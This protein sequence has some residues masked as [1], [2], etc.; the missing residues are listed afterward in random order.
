MRSL[1]ADYA[2]LPGLLPEN[3]LLLTNP[4]N[5]RLV[6]KLTLK[7]L[8][9]ACP[10]STRNRLYM[11]RE[12]SLRWILKDFEVRD[13]TIIWEWHRQ[14]K[15]PNRLGRRKMLTR[16]LRW[17]GPLVPTGLLNFSLGVG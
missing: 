4:I 7:G 9:Q 3:A 6:G 14:S 5:S 12:F 16:F 8:R 10:W 2:Q 11:M 17:P 1:T 13:G 15:M